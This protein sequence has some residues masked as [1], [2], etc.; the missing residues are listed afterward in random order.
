MICNKK[1][2]A[3]II[4][5]LLSINIIDCTYAPVGNY[6]ITSGLSHSVVTSVYLS[7]DDFVWIATTDG[8]NRYD[9]YNFRKYYISYKER[10]ISDHILEIYETSNGDIWC[11]TLYGIGKLN[12]KDNVFVPAYS[13]IESHNLPYNEKI[14]DA[15]FDADKEEIYIMGRAFIDKFNCEK[16]SSIQL[17]QKK[18]L[19]AYNIDELNSI[20]FI[21]STNELIL[22]TNNG[23]YKYDLTHQKLE[24]I[25]ELNYKNL[26]PV[27][28]KKHVF[29]YD[30]NEIW[31]YSIATN[32]LRGIE[33]NEYIDR[34]GSLNL[35]KPLENSLL[36]LFEK[37]V[38]NHELKLTEQSEIFRID[39]N[40]TE[41]VIP[42]S[43]TISENN[44]FWLGSN[45]GVLKFNFHN[46]KYREFDLSKEKDLFSNEKVK[47]ISKGI[48]NRLL[49]TLNSGRVYEVSIDDFKITNVFSAGFINSIYNPDSLSVVF[50]TDDGIVDKLN[51]NEFANGI[52]VKLSTKVNGRYYYVTDEGVFIENEKSGIKND[53]LLSKMVDPSSLISMIKWKEEVLFV[54]TRYIL[55][56]STKNYKTV[57]YELFHTYSNRSPLINSSLIIKNKLWL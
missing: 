6:M 45:V 15:T 32:K 19:T 51:N 20:I 57:K 7:K 54:S 36:L 37:G 48:G 55:K 29:L 56:Y 49:L 11:P 21:E 17:I 13:M 5:W 1:T 38:V 9:G 42:S 34:L 12:I 31:Q 39:Y 40:A 25:K 10:L 14:V 18:D 52:D 41:K 53:S 23:L 43:M 28:N 2:Y 27:G 46:N 50:N 24:P 33:I 16:G 22:G 44:V 3:L 4:A 47:Q 26:K 30:N 8:L 35:V